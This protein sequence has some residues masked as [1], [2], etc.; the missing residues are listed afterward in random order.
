MKKM[1]LGRGG[2][3]GKGVE[4][5]KSCQKELFSRAAR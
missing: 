5:F 4:R 1:R 3:C 2:K